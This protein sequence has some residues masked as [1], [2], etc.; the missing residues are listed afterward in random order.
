M[1][2]NE[3]IRGLKGAG[4]V[5]D[6]YPKPEKNINEFTRYKYGRRWKWIYNKWEIARGQTK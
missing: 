6:L 2:L 5:K 3:A 1:K 4:K